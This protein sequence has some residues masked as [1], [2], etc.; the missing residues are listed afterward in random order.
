MNQ[1]HIS[2]LEKINIPKSDLPRI[3]IIGGGFGGLRFVK[4]I[5]T[6]KYQ[7]VLL[8]RYNY[9]TFQPL[10]YQ[11]ATAGLE[12]DSIAGPLRKTFQKK[13]NFFFRMA[14]A[15][16][17]DP[18]EKIVETN[19]GELSYDH[20]ILAC[21]SIT[22]FFNNEEFEQK[23]FPLKQ[24]P[25]ALNL[26]S[27][28]LQNFEKAVLKNDENEVQRLMNYVIVGGGP[29]G[30]EVAG[31]LGELKKH[32]LPKDFPELNLN[33]MQIYLVE[34]QDRLLGGMS[35]KSG[36]KAFEYLKKFDVNL[37]VGK[38]VKSFDGETV[39]LNDG[40][41]IPSETLIW[42]AGVNGNALTGMDQKVT[43]DK[44]Y[45]VNEFNKVEGFDE[46]YAIG[47]VASMKS[48]EFERGHP[49]LAPVAIQQAE[50]LAKNLNKGLEKDNWKPF[51]YVDKG[52][53]AT[54]GRNKA[55]T[56]VFGKLKF[57]GFMAWLMWMF[58]HLVLIV[59]FRN[60]IVIMSNWVWNYFTYDR[61][62]RLIIRPFVKKKYKAKKQAEEMP[63]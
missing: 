11:V 54:V 47:D 49:M 59:E 10:L 51:K 21:G 29:T 3:V 18:V 15:H 26:R 58:V 42:A 50:L 8:D 40:M 14:S 28:I 48:E 24:L 4:R 23:A 60:K 13:K 46:V 44:R 6:R 52:T 34:G 57:G 38:I 17:I 36:E 1:A 43:R 35:E 19:I 20:L 37:Y 32:V 22:N 63:V 56:E 5:D 7:V 33:K 31:A 27:Q 55:V 25:H 41:Q 12:P 39:E 2:Q 53:M 16:K 62:T 45:Q 61:G 30:V 9:H